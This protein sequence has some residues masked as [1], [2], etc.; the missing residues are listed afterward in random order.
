MTTPRLCVAAFGGATAIITLCFGIL[1]Q[2][3]DAWRLLVALVP[4]LIVFIWWMVDRAALERRIRRLEA[5]SEI[6]NE[7]RVTAQMGFTEVEHKLHEIEGRVVGIENF[8]SPIHASPDQADSLEKENG[9][10]HLQVMCVD[11]A[12]SVRLPVNPQ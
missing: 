4:L 12:I 10:R 8:T 2:S 9:T 5:R 6:A 11:K 3:A 1:H 7:R